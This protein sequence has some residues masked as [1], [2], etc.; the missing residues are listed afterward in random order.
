MGQKYYIRVSPSYPDHGGDYKIAFSKIPIP[1][2]A[3][4]LTE[5]ISAYNSI[6]DAN[7]IHWY[8]FTATNAKQYV[9]FD[10]GTL[11]NAFLQVYDKNGDIVETENKAETASYGFYFTLTVG[12]DY[13]IRVR[14]AVGNG[15]YSVV[16]NR[17]FL[18]PFLT[19]NPLTLNTWWNVQYLS[20]AHRGMWF[21]FTATAA[22]QYLHFDMSSLRGEFTY[23]PCDS[24]G[25]MIPVNGPKDSGNISSWSVS[26]RQGQQY[27]I[28]LMSTGY[29]D[30]ASLRL[31]FNASAT[32]P[33]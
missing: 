5:N 14:R 6:T 8:K 25:D 7:S 20:S 32:P 31:A 24:N 27:Y 16:F 26:L 9:H 1:P 2:G 23:F 33:K 18:A 28:Y 21:R 30:L 13:Y 3:V 22:T 10:W 19:I 4:E 15:T 11:N 17:S 29:N 12:E